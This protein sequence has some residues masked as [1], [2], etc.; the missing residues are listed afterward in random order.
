LFLGY[1]RFPN[2][3][4]RARLTAIVLPPGREIERPFPLVI[5]KGKADRR[6]GVEDR[7]GQLVPLREA[8][9][10]VH[11][12]QEVFRR[13]QGEFKDCVRHHQQTLRYAP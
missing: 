13:M 6:P 9:T 10:Q 11:T 12:S 7:M 2:L 5:L 1:T 4:P 8:E 3:T